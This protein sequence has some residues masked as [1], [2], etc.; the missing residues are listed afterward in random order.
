MRAWG[1]GAVRAR[2]LAWFTAEGPCRAGP[3]GAPRE[4]V[5]CRGCRFH[6]QGPPERGGTRGALT[7]AHGKPRTFKGAQTPPWGARRTWCMIADHL[8]S[9]PLQAKAPGGGVHG[10]SQSLPGPKS[11]S[12]GEEGKG[13]AAELVPGSA[14]TLPPPHSLWPRAHGS[15][16]GP[17]DRGEG[18]ECQGPTPGMLPHAGQPQA[19]SCTCFPGLPR[20]TGGP[21][22]EI[23]GPAVRQWGS[24]RL[25]GE[26]SRAGLAPLGLRLPGWV[27]AGGAGSTIPGWQALEGLLQ[28]PQGGRRDRRQWLWAGGTRLAQSGP[29]D[30]SLDRENIRL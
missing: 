3:A 27:I 25:P 15:R 19:G 2:T 1:G 12:P 21:R 17:A 18:Q 11:E 24:G 5:L 13:W 22:G 14:H 8:L 16:A 9:P 7:V 20:L 10:G 23:P 30:G 4:G 28:A 6:G 29:G 26:Q